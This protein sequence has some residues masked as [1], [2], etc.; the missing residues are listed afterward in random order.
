[1]QN[2]Y[3]PVSC[4]LYDQLELLAMRKT[5]IQLG[6]ESEHMLSFTEGVIQDL[7]TDEDHV[8]FLKFT[9]GQVIRLDKLKVLNGEPVPNYC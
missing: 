9:D 2:K 7:Y 8:E 3:I 1:M 4:A 5:R 6:Y